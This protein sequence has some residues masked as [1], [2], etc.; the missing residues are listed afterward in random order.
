MSDIY[1]TTLQYASSQFKDKGSKFIGHIYSATSRDE[2]ESRVADIRKEYFDATHNC[3][4]FRIGIGDDALFH[5]DDDGEPSGTAGKPIYQAIQGADL[6]NVVIIVT[7]YYGGTKL[8]TGGLI[9]AYGYSAKLTIDQAKVIEK[10]LAKKVTVK[11]DY[12]D[13]SLVMRAIESFQGKL[14]SQ[15][16]SDSVQITLAAPRSQVHKLKLQ[17][18]EQSAGR[19]QFV[20]EAEDL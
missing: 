15:E 11:T 10:T 12:D 17:L 13:M 14:I 5:Y 19:I 20:R 7:R 4:A 2:V 3:S 8:G 18:K 9:R 16:Y 6:T 1:R